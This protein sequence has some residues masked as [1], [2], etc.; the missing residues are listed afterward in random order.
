[1]PTQKRS[2]R[3]YAHIHG[4]DQVLL[5]VLDSVVLNP[6]CS[7]TFN[8]SEYAIQ[9]DGLKKKSVNAL[10]EDTIKAKSSE[11]AKIG[12]GKT[13]HGYGWRCVNHRDC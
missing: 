9:F 4:N 10:N 1:M 7:P 12:M 2:E 11:C 3:W 6:F 13:Y 5:D 8:R